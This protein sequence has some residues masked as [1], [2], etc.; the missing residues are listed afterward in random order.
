MW[1]PITP[2][3]EAQAVNA[4]AGI[5]ILYSRLDATR[6]SQI[7][8]AKALKEAINAF[9]SVSPALTEQEIRR[10]L[11]RLL[12][13]WTPA[14]LVPIED[15][16]ALEAEPMNT[17]AIADIDEAA[18]QWVNELSDEECWVYYYRSLDIPDAVTAERIGK[19]RPTVVN[20]KQRVLASAGSKLLS[21]MAP[22]HH[23]DAV[24]CAQEHCA[25]RLGESL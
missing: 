19:S 14:S 6:E 22:Q 17:T 25:R 9:F 1:A 15:N 5:P 8:T 16:Y 2:Q 23:L 20:I 4:A 10:I 7:F 18:S 13:P 11:E 21:E 24:K 3:Q 12:T